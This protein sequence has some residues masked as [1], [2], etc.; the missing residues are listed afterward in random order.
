[1]KGSLYA[2]EHVAGYWV[3]NL[4]ESVVETYR[5]SQEDSSARFGWSYAQSKRVA[6]TESIALPFGGVVSAADLL[7]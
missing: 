5:D 2:R 1:V 7:P 4:N 6:R 3:I